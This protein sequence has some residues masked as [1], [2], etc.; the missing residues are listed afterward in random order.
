METEDGVWS[1]KRMSV[2]AGD[3]VIVMIRH[4]AGQEP[5]WTM[6]VCRSF[7]RALTIT[8]ADLPA[9]AAAMGDVALLLVED[10]PDA[11]ALPHVPSSFL[12]RCLLVTP[13]TDVSVLAER[14]AMVPF[15]GFLPLPLDPVLL[16][17]RVERAFA[18]HRTQRQLSRQQ[19][20]LNRQTEAL[21]L[22]IER[23]AC[24]EEE[25]RL[26]RELAEVSNHAKTTFLANMS[27][28]LRTPLNAIIGFTEMI[29]S[30]LFGGIGNPVYTDYLKSIHESA[31]QLLGIINDILDISK[32][33]VG[34]VVLTER[35]FDLRD[36]V[37]SATRLVRPAASGKRHSMSIDLPD[38]PLMVQGDARV[39]KQVIYNILANAVKFT[40]DEGKITVKTEI[41][42]G[43]P[44]IHIRDNGIGMAPETLRA[45]LRPFI[46]ADDDGWTRRFQGTGLGLPL[47]KSYMQLHGGD[48][49]LTSMPGEGTLVTLRLP[50]SRLLLD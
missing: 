30:E 22:E 7:P 19:E 46:Q 43:C 50:A 38:A 40:A 12:G 42:A 36:I 4:T 23:R 20:A 39:I 2:E 1:E 27:H 11:P 10:G 14:L 49:E 25:A 48:L 18:H 13:T 21:T 24:A 47:A 3:Q 34:K 33:E 35:P 8:T 41:T 37:A 17:R 15:D 28:E 26:A 45:V 44:V 9:L 29:L 32:I 16:N 31:Y 5:D 6:A